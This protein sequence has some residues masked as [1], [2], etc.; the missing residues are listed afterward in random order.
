MGDDLKLV[1]KKY[2][3]SWVQTK[4]GDYIFSHISYLFF[5]DLVG[6][7]QKIIF[8]IVIVCFLLA[9]SQEEEDS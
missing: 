1:F 4:F 2:I 5:L 3:S 7:A 6:I 9:E 8:L